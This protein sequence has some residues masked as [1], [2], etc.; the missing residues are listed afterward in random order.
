MHDEKTREALLSAAEQLL[1]RGGLDAV[2]TRAVA[3]RAGTTTRAVYSLFDSKAELLHQLAVRAFGTLVDL[4]ESVPQTADPGLDL[5]NAGMAFR[6]WALDHPN[7]FRLVFGLPD[8][9]VTDPAVAPAGQAAYRQLR[10]L[11]D[12]A[13]NAGLLGNRPPGEVTAEWDALCEGLASVELG[14]GRLM[15][16]H[17][18]ERMWRDSLTAFLHGLSQPD[19]QQPPAADNSD[20]AAPAHPPVE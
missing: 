20:G 10:Q 4:V 12:R 1:T 3:D 17:K 15:P 16:P 5:I 19:R 8:G 6:S 2:S 9:L 18:A 7:L 14:G 13:R 11:V